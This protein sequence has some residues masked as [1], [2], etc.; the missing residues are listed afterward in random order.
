MQKRGLA[1]NVNKYLSEFYIWGEMND[2]HQ[3]LRSPQDVKPFH[4]YAP[5]GFINFKEDAKMDF[6]FKLIHYAFKF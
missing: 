5:I 6:V 2:P 3:S 1:D 4:F